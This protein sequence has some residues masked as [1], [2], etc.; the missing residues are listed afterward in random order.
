MA[1]DPK[2]F[3]DFG[4]FNLPRGKM[5]CVN[6]TFDLYLLGLRDSVEDWI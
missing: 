3:L 5:L 4:K 1:E 6:T 2:G